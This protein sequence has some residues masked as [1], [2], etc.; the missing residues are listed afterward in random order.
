MKNS[1][2]LFIIIAFFF[3]PF[4]INAQPPCG[5]DDLHKKLLATDSAYA[6][7]IE[8]HNIAIRKYIESH[9]ELKKPSARLMAAYTIPVVVHVMHT[10]GAIGTIYNPSDAQIMGAINYLNQVYAGTYPGM[11]APAPG[12][13]AGDIEI[14]FALA[15]RTPTCGATNGIDRVDASSIPNYTSFGVNS[16]NS[17]GVADLTLKDFAR[18]NAADYYNIW[19]VNKIDGAD[20][21]SGQFIAGYAYFAGASA[22]LDGTV[23]LATQMVSGAKTLPHEIGHALNLYHPFQGSADNTQCPFN[24][25]CTTQGDRICDT[26][27][28]YHNF[29]S[30]TGVISFACRS[31]A[32]PCA[33][34]N[35]YSI[36][37][38]S[39][40]MSYTT[41]YTLFT[42]DQKARMQAAMSLSSRASLVSASNM[43][44]VPCGIVINFSLAASSKTEDITGILTGCRTYKDYSYQMVIGDAPGAAATATLTYSGTATKGLDYDVTT[45]GNFASPDDVLT[46]AN[47]VT[48]AQLFTVRIYD[49]GNVEPA[50]TI[51]IDFTVDDGGGDAAKG[52]NTPTFTLT[53]SDNDIAP[54]G[55][56]SG[57]TAQIGISAG[58]INAAPFD[59][60]QQSMRSQFLYRA[61]ELTAAGVPAG[62]ITALQLFINT[63]ASTRPFTNFTI[64]MGHSTLNYLVDASVTVAGGLPTVYTN[65]SLTTAAGWNNFNFTTPFTWDGTN[66]LVIEICYDNVTAN[67][68]SGQDAI[69]VYA[70]GNGPAVQGNWFFQNDITC[71]GSFS[72]VS[73]AIY[74]PLIKFS[75]FATG[76]IIE[77]TAGATT[78]GHIDAGS[79]DY[80]YSNN[81]KLL[82]RLN[83]I[84]DPL[85]CVT[86]TLDEGG[87]NWV[88]YF[89]GERSAKIFAISPTTNASTATYE[90]ALYFDNAELDGKIASNLRIA[91]TSAASA[92]TANASNT[93][94]VTP[95]VAVLGSGTTV[96]TASFTGFSRFFLVDPAVI[97][98]IV[99]TDFTGRANNEHNTLL[100]WVTSSE[101]NN[102]QF[103][104]EI[105]RDGINFALL[106][107]V[108]SQGNSAVPQKYEYLHVKP[109][110]GLTWYRLKQT[111][112]DGK[113]AYSKIIFVNIDKGIVR[114]FVYPVPA[115]DM[116][117]VTF[118]SIITKG[119]IEIFSAD[120][121]NIKRESIDGPSAKKDMNI[122][123]IPQGVY[124]IRI[125]NGVSNEILRFIKE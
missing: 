33:S 95:T 68:G 20:G 109:P 49:D 92:A 106:A 46:F 101:E 104:I 98:P 105:S 2:L 37:T 17:N 82:I 55:A 16:A 69:R 115:R 35:N 91:K 83:N 26:D 53:L 34:P 93:V 31:G 123:G 41:C 99:L 32:N 121:K 22:S 8:Q 84:S 12:G 50:E 27:P 24:A 112:R 3:I 47:G 1:F 116:I 107:T 86:S 77:T 81:S 66:N 114:S 52:T 97:L 36:N 70:D 10:G 60:K 100:N 75:Y 30:G 124:F 102:R 122:S 43:A 11:T 7:Q 65:A 88:S 9:P 56:G 96:F 73:Y 45:N 110:S 4:S 89:G 94:M 76:T 38:E 74:K 18:W 42:N 85:G 44:L 117:T 48:T 63:K 28:I 15:Q 67:A 51:I 6:R 14:Q 29:N 39:N 87:T 119:A 71:S 111:D 72:S 78:T 58:T 25:D 79:N 108:V 21:T 103:D 13:A 23:M 62:D 61:S 80:F 64:N 5:F 125:S 19:V 118:G 90:A 57:T 59:A 54:S 113:Y 120:M 40:F